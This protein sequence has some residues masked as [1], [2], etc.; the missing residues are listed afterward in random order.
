MN[1]TAGEGVSLMN[2]H[3]ATIRV[4]NPV[5]PLP[6]AC[7]KNRKAELA[8]PNHIGAPMPGVVAT[9]AA[10]PSVQRSKK[11]ICPAD[12][13]KRMK[14]ETRHPCRPATL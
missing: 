2:G 3:P 5:W 1:E 11:R 8:N 9:V 10:V 7:M 14:M 13:L 4:L 6:T 12:D